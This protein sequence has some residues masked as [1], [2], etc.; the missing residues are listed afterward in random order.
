[1]GSHLVALAIQQLPSY[2]LLGAALVN[3]PFVVGLDGG[4]GLP[5]VSH[6]LSG[7]EVPGLVENLEIVIC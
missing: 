4:S 2:P 1:M 5:P 6:I 7:S 3:Q